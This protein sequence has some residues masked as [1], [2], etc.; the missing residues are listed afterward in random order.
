[1]RPGNAIVD[2]CLQL[3]KACVLV[4][5]RRYCQLCR[6]DSTPGAHYSGIA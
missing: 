4:M 6:G 5:L 2:D 1:V 3:C